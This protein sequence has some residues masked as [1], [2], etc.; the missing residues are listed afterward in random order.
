M[1]PLSANE[2]ARLT[3]RNTRKN[4]VWVAQ[5]DYREVKVD[6][7]KP[8]SPSAKIPRIGGPARL[9][10]EQAANARADRARKRNSDGDAE[11]AALP[12]AS[13][14]ATT[15]P[16]THRLGQGET[17]PYE[18]PVRGYKAKGVRWHK[19]LFVGP[20]D[21]YTAEPA[22]ELGARDLRTVPTQPAKSVLSRKV[23]PARKV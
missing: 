20:S 3:T 10:K 6:G 17:S 9:S 14:L 1:M 11:E 18:S 2:L 13:A 21:M 5:L 23:S 19:T 16:L 7:A 22:P 15:T 8:P 4:E 12:P